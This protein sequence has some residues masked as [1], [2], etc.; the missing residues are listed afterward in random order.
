MALNCAAVGRLATIP[1]AGSSA[2]SLT[3]RLRMAVYVS[4]NETELVEP[5]I[6]ELPML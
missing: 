2:A 1:S 4:E 6:V 3:I 5:R